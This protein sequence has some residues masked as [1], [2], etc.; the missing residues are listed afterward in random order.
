MLSSSLSIK[1]QID[2]YYEVQP[3]I[4]KDGYHPTIGKSDDKPRIKENRSINL[5]L[6]NAVWIFE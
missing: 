3:R 2:I 5:P 4:K 6:A 1:L